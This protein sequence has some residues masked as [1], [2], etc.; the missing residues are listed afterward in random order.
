M[1]FAWRKSPPSTPPPVMIDSFVCE[2]VRASRFA[3]APTKLSVFPTSTPPE[4]VPAQTC[5]VSPA[6]AAVTADWMSLKPGLAQLVLAP[7]VASS[8]THCVLASAVP[9]NA[10]L[11]PAHATATASERRTMRKIT[12]TS[13]SRCGGPRPG[14]ALPPA[15][16]WPCAAA[17]VWRL[18]AHVRFRQRP[19]CD[20]PAPPGRLIWLEYG[21]TA[22]YHRPR[23]W[24]DG[25]DGPDAASRGRRGGGRGA[26]PRPV[27][28]RVGRAGHLGG[29]PAGASPADGRG[30]GRVRRQRAAHGGGPEAAA[31]VPAD[32][33]EDEGRSGAERRAHPLRLPDDHRGEHGARP[34][35][36]QRQGRVPGGRVRRAD[37]RPALVAHHRL[38]DAVIRQRPLRLDSSA[39]RC[40]D[41]SHGPCRRRC[42]G[43]RDPAPARQ[44]EDRGGAAAG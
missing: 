38:S 12:A 25:H 14:A 19:E 23:R 9:A 27:A 5:T 37:R 39:A 1:P 44:P 7:T 30:V 11:I 4:Y 3:F 28:R 21:A 18:L 24:R 15:P 10:T 17:T 20:D 26:R 31:A 36:G 41:A 16:I 6:V 42:R 32:P 13:S 22:A 40:A 35:P 2:R 33:L 29:P 43:N 34:D 8:F